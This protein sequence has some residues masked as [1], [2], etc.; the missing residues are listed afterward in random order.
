VRLP[1]R[2]GNSMSETEVNP[3]QSPEARIQ[4]R[5][6]YAADRPPLASL[7]A[8]LGAW[9]LDALLGAV[10]SI[11]LLIALVQFAI[12]H[13]DDSDLPTE[14]EMLEALFVDY[15]AY[16]AVSLGLAVLLAIIHLVFFVQSSQS[17]GK[18]IVG[19]Q[20]ATLDGRPAGLLRILGL[21]IIVAGILYNLPYIG[22]VIGLVGIL[23]I[24][25]VDR[26]CLHDYIAGTIV[27]QYR[28]V[29]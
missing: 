19:T 22:I 16:V 27:V 3:Y 6:L 9:V 18:R 10:A 17:I 28:P 15:P 25:S 7:G 14:D 12:L 26:R 23:M 24:F 20:I 21:R 29:R 2:R 4:D 5:R 13:F 11:P 8:R 1:L